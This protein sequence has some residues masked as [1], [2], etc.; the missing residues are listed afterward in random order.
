MTLK[1]HIGEG[2]LCAITIMELDVFSVLR[3]KGFSIY[4][5]SWYLSTSIV[6]WVVE[7]NLLGEELKI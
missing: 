4:T 6:R 3:Y 1:A 2:V 7:F 5:C